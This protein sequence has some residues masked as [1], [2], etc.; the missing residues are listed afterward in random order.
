MDRPESITA[1]F[2]DGA[3]IDAAMDAAAAAAVEAH[4]REGLPLAV[5]ADGR[6]AWVDPSELPPASE[7]ED[8]PPADAG[9]ARR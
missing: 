8:A 7:R 3:R 2:L 5:W 6:V 4:R 1:L 9:S